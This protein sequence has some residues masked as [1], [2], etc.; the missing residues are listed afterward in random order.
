MGGIIKICSRVDK[1]DQMGKD[2]TDEFMW[3]IKWKMPRKREICMT[4]LC[5][6]H[7]IINFYTFRSLRNILSR[8][9]EGKFYINWVSFT[10]IQVTK[11]FTFSLL[12]NKL[13]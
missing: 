6:C 13:Y 7:L 10:L 12:Y 5:S 4:L 9:H 11:T 2:D 8:H 1:S 3:G